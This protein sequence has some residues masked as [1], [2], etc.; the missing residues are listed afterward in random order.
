M[1]HKSI[2]DKLKSATP[3][4]IGQD[5]IKR[6]S[7]LLPLIEK[8]DG[9]HLLFE[10]RSL[11]MRRQPGEV[12]FPGGKVDEEDEDTQYT[13]VREAVEELGVRRDRIK[14]IYSFGYMVSPFGMKVDAYVGFLKCDEQDLT[15]NPKEVAEV[16]TVPLDFLLNTEPD[17]HYIQMEVQPEGEFPY[18][19]IPNGENYKWSKRRYAEHF[20]Y[21]GD[22]VIWGLTARIL[23]DFIQEIRK[24]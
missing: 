15:P 9:M 13:A 16:F 22:Q 14:D 23:H 20:Y 19:L 4:L 12:C 18:H 21:Y 8:E 10:V 5:H 7:L 3:K 11:N 24:Q 2:Q 17:I 6:Y 1:N